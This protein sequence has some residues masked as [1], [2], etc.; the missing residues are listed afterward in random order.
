[1]NNTI[2]DIVHKSPICLE[3]DSDLD[4]A[5]RIMAEKR[6]SC[7]LVTESGKLCGILTEKDVVRAYDAARS[8][9]QVR[10]RQ[11]M[12]ASPMT[13]K[14]SMGHLEAYRLMQDRGFRHLPVVDDEGGIV[15]IVTE[16]D[17]V[18]TLGNDYYIRLKDV[19]TVMVPVTTLP[20]DVPLSQAL[21]LLTESSISS[22]VIN[23]DGKGMGIITERD[24]VRLVRSGQDPVTTTTAQV[25]QHPIITVHRDSSLLEASELLTRHRIRRLVVVDDHGLPVG[26]L[27]QHEIVRGLENEYIGHLEGVIAEK[28]KALLELNHMHQR[29]EDQSA[30]LQQTLDELSSAHSELGE[31]TKIAAHDL[32][33]PLRL[34]QTNAFL[35]KRELGDNLPS[36]ASAIMA[37]LLENAERAQQ[38]VRDMVNYATTMDRTKRLE[39]MNA[40]DCVDL[41]MAQ[42]AHEIREAGADIQIG[43]LPKVYAARTVL[44]EVMSTLLSNALKFRA[45]GVKPKIQISSTD[46]PTAWLFT[47]KDN[48][49]GIESRYHER[50]F[51]L[52][53]RLHPASVYAGSGVGLAI[54]R[55]L[56]EMLGGTI[57]LES[58]LNRGTEFNFTIAKAAPAAGRTGE[59]PIA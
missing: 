19:A 10:L 1:M 56:V 52:F 3:A 21:Q 39:S 17:Y 29:V 7:L 8:P 43:P 33:E 51:G 53:S 22:V 42:L 54:C 31:F 16:S 25:M 47:V 14:G 38:M 9:G 48:G 4:D 28:N 24:V 57:W 50:I 26:M 41:A 45:S 55:R 32:Q 2:M 12:T 49:I 35:L 40:R 15:G 6:I 37:A 11:V 23:D 30:L 34:L 36:S 59:P 44:V 58:E 20:G 27:S 46:T 13:V 5:L 18:R